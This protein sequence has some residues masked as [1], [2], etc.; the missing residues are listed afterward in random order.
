MNQ[1]KDL[2]DSF[3]PTS[4]WKQFIRSNFERK[5]NAYNFVSVSRLQI[6]F[7]NKVYHF[8]TKIVFDYGWVKAEKHIK[9][10]E[11]FLEGSEWVT[12]TETKTITPFGYFER[13][14][15]FSG[16]FD[17]I[18]EDVIGSKKR[19]ASLISENLL[20]TGDNP[21]YGIDSLQQWPAYIMVLQNTNS[22]AGSF[23]DVPDIWNDLLTDYGIHYSF[24]PS[25]YNTTIVIFPMRYIK[26]LE[27][28]I[29]RKEK[30]SIFVVLEFNS[31]PLFYITRLNIEIKAI[32]KDTNDQVYEQR[33]IVKYEKTRFQ[34][35]DIIPEAPCEVAFSDISVL[36]NNTLV[37]RTSGYYIRN[38]KIDVKSGQK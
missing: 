37:N 21:L 25:L 20:Q 29:R 8:P 24:D 14:E 13:R 36:I 10:T 34:T 11:K 33:Q 27:N 6:K 35:V 19:F 15:R 7:K 9:R 16:E 3:Q 1:L 31:L 5:S 17:E 22:R 4:D 32:I 38:I 23:Q 12:I 2:I 30:E 18:L 26:I 28:R